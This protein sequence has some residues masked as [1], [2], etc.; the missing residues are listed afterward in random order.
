NYNTENIESLFLQ[1]T[2]K[3]LTFVLGCIYRPP[4]SVLNDDKLLFQTL[5]ELASNNNKVFIFGDFNLPDVKWP[6]E[7]S[8]NYSGSSQLLVDLLLS[9]HLIQ[10][11]DQPTRYRAGQQP[12]TLD[13]II[14]SDDDLLANLEY[15]DPVGNSDHVV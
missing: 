5:S 8:H 6:L 14:T 1:V 15:L 3:T 12:S 13:L 7:M 2:D 9:H 11:V 10:L 4:S